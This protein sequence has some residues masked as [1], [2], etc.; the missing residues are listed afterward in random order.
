[1]P[2]HSSWLFSRESIQ[3]NKSSK[4]WQVLIELWRGKAMGTMQIFI[5]H[6]C[7][8]GRI[9]DICLFIGIC[10]WIKSSKDVKIVKILC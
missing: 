5:S 9:K 1:M 4:F 2:M 10:K 8:L 7:I 6:S 3:C